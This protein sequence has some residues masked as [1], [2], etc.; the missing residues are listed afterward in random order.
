MP[1]NFEKGR[2]FDA[3][4]ARLTDP[5]AKRLARKRANQYY[6]LDLKESKQR[7]QQAKPQYALFR[8]LACVLLVAAI[9][10]LGAFEAQKEFPTSNLWTVTGCV[11]ILLLVIAA[12]VFVIKGLMSEGGFLKFSSSIASAF[13]RIQQS[14][15]DDKHSGDAD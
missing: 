7:I 2:A 8:I 4:F 5:E 1:T 12:I 9:L 10:A 13:G 14:D 3:E 15:D 6:G 11:A